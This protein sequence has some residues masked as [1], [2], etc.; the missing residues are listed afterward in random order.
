MLEPWIIHT[1]QPDAWVIPTDPCGTCAGEGCANCVNGR[2]PQD[3][4]IVLR[5]EVQPGKRFYPSTHDCAREGCG[6]VLI[7]PIKEI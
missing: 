2:V 6:R 3:G 5:H 1:D 4:S 7:I